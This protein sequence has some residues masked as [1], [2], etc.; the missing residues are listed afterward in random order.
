MINVK[1]ATHMKDKTGDREEAL[2]QMIDIITKKQK[3]VYN[4]EEL[5][6]F[7]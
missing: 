7:Y 1:N 4:P 3:E 6:K 2:K 5:R